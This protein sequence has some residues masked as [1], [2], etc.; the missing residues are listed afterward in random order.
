MMFSIVGRDCWVVANFKETQLEHM[1]VGQKARVHVDAY[2]VDFDGHVESI[3]AGSGAHFSLLPPQNATGNYV[4][5]VQRVPVK[6]VLDGVADNSDFVL[7][8]GISAFPTV[9]ER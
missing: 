9:D 4:K 5:V 1:R 2:D 6:I 7:G 3:Q 8:P